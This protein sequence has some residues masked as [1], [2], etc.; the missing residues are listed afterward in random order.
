MRKLVKVIFITAV[1][2][3][4][5]PFLT[6]ADDTNLINIAPLATVT[7]R[8]YSSF[9][10]RAVD[11]TN[12]T[13]VSTSYNEYIPSKTFYF[14]FDFPVLI[15]KIS[16]TLPPNFYSIWADT[17]G[18]GVYDKELLTVN[19]GPTSKLWGVPTW[20][21]A[22]WNGPSTSVYGVKYEIPGI[23][24]FVKS[25]SSGTPVQI[26]QMVY[27]WDINGVR[28]HR[29]GTIVAMDDTNVWI[30]LSDGEGWSW[31]SSGWM[32]ASP[33]DPSNRWVY[34]TAPVDANP[35]RSLYEFLIFGD[36]TE[37]SPST[38]TALAAVS[39]PS[40][41]NNVPVAMTG[42]PLALPV[43]SVDTLYLK[44]MYLEV[45][46]MGL[47]EWIGKTP[48]R[49]LRDWPNYKS[50]VARMH[51]LS[52][53]LAWLMP[54]R[55][56]WV[57]GKNLNDYL[58]SEVLWPSQYIASSSPENYLAKISTALHA[59]GIKLFAG[60]RPSAWT[61]KSGVLQSDVWRGA[62][63]EMAASGVDGVA[64]CFDEGGNQASADQLSQH[65]AA[66]DAVHAVDPNIFTFTNMQVPDESNRTFSTF[67]HAVNVNLL[68]TE[69]YFTLDDPLGHWAP[70]IHMA[71]MNGANP[72]QGA[73]NTQNT[74]WAP[75]TGNPLF[76]ETFPPVALYGP[77]LSTVFHEAKAISYWRLM[78]QNDAYTD[79]NVSKGY[80][81][82]DTLS[83]WGGHEAV[84]PEGVLVLESNKQASRFQYYDYVYHLL[85]SFP[86]A[87]KTGYT[88]NHAAYETLLK[89]GIP[90]KTRYVEYPQE[91]PDQANVKVIIVTFAYIGDVTIPPETMAYLQS[92]AN[93]GTKIVIL[94]R[95][96]VHAYYKPFPGY[97][98][99]I[100]SPHVTVVP[101]DLSYGVT[102]AIR[103]H[104][105]A[106]VLSGLGSDRPV[107]LNAYGQDVE[108]AVMT[109]TGSNAG[110]KYLLVTNWEN[111]AV[112]VDVGVNAP[113][114]TYKVLQRDLTQVKPLM[115]EGRDVLT[116]EEVA[117][118]RISLAVG[119]SRIFFVSPYALSLVGD[120]SG[121]GK[122]TM[123]DAAL[124]L[125]YTIGGTLTPAQQA[126]ADINGDAKVDAADAVAIARK[127][128]GL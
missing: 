80:A 71:E 34:S 6:C 62:A 68:G 83:A 108:V 103:D 60:D 91:F 95:P 111:H 58:G 18:N 47:A 93:S 4:M 45:W 104:I 32:A 123:Y 40:L 118:F 65:A 63:G 115:I 10:K 36:K 25:G 110:N 113:A 109:G 7:S 92:A 54:V 5:C 21:F 73:I 26:G 89:A 116:A 64:V 57:N 46:M 76:Y 66:A 84:V 49:D 78:F 44:G 24:Q 37:L 22:S 86:D 13:G 102:P 126:R 30:R 127:A 41:E 119:E 77:T 87:N 33:T 124:V 85:P 31:G 9:L 11:G 101:D 28:Q 69:G 88:N 19:N 79:A 27:Q 56:G 29:S 106:P 96:G 42:A 98:I 61:A 70:A 52:A 128:V 81:M 82:L 51:A 2:L 99:L 90:F 50:M 112:T 3:G 114:G 74:A 20:T 14:R 12:G 97:D 105:L 43:P 120:L 38:L 107:Y 125:K 53:N 67:S 16:C 72:M 17:T 8:P 1:L 59:D 94:H 100:Q 48:R 23:Y 35:V 75:A 15:K 121:D 39:D 117:K 55:S 122:V